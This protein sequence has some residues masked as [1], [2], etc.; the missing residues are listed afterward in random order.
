MKDI[1]RMNQLAGIITEGQARKML[2][3]LNEVNQPYKVLSKKTGKSEYSDNMYDDY[4]LEL[5]DEN[6]TTPS[7]LT[8]R[9]RTLGYITI[10][11][12]VE[13]DL[14]QTYHDFYRITNYIMDE[15]GNRLEWIPGRTD[16]YRTYNPKASLT[17][18]KKWLDKNGEKLMS[19]KRYRHE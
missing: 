16:L 19:G 8:F 11:T 3:V 17:K 6:Y 2:K 5:Y 13:L 7:G 15:N 1:I 18:V 4:E 9:I 14:D 12:G 10:H